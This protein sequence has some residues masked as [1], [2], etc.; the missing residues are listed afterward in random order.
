MGDTK[1]AAE[2]PDNTLVEAAVPTP[3]PPAPTSPVLTSTEP[4]A[5]VAAPTPRNSS[6]FKG[7]IGTGGLEQPLQ[8]SV[9]TQNLLDDK[10]ILSATRVDVR[11]TRVPVLG[12]IQLLA[13]LGQGGMG[14]VYY[15]VH[16]R[17]H[18]EVAVKVL[19]FHLAEQEPG[20][21]P[22]FIREAQ[23][24]AKVRSPHLVGVIDVNEEN[25]LFFLV[26]EFI[27]GK[28][29]GELLRDAA[30]KGMRGLPEVTA[31]G[32]CIGAA[33]GLAAA[34]SHGVIHRDI[35][36][37]N[38]MIPRS[39]GSMEAID[40]QART[41][42]P[43]DA[44]FD[45]LSAKLADLGL[46]RNESGDAS[47]TGANVCMG[48]P[49][50]MSPEQ[51]SDAKHASKPAD[52]FSL[53]ATLYALLSGDSPFK[54]SSL[55]QTLNL[56]V[57]EPHKPITTLRADV[58]PKTAALLDRCLGKKEGDRF[59]D[60]SALLT[61]LRQSFEALVSSVQMSS[62]KTSTIAPSTTVD[63]NTRNVPSSKIS[64][65]IPVSVLP[66][67]PSQIVPAQTSWLPIFATI[68]FMLAIV[69]VGGYYVWQRIEAA[70]RADQQALEANQIS[71]KKEREA[72]IAREQ[73]EAIEK[74]DEMRQA[75]YQ[76]ELRLID[77]WA[78]NQR[79]NEATRRTLLWETAMTA[80]AEFRK[81]RSLDKAIET[82]ENALNN[83]NTIP[84]PGRAIATKMLSDL[85]E[86]RSKVESA[87]TTSL[88]SAAEA[89]REFNFDKTIS[90][91]DA[92][93]KALG[94]QSHPSRKAGEFMLSEAKRN[95]QDA[96]DTFAT[97]YK[98]ALDF[99]R[100]RSWQRVVLTLDSALKSLGPQTHADRSAVEALLKEGR[101]EIDKLKVNGEL[102]MKSLSAAY[103]AAQT[104]KAARNW[105]GVLLALE[106]PLKAIGDQVHPNR[107]AVESLIKE[108]KDQ[109]ERQRLFKVEMEKGAGLVKDLNFDAAKT[110]FENARKTTQDPAELSEINAGLVLVA[111]GIKR[112]KYSRARGWMTQGRAL[113]P[114]LKTAKKGDWTKAL[115]AFKS[116]A[117][118]Y[119][120]LDD[121][122]DLARA[123]IEQGDCLRKD[124]NQNGDW[125]LAAGL[126]SSATVLLGGGVGDK[127]TLAE[128][129]SKHAACLDPDLNPAGDA[130]QAAAMYGRAASMLAETGNKRAAADNFSR[131]ATCLSKEKTTPA[132]ADRTADIFKRAAVLYEELGEKKLQGLCIFN[133]AA[134]LIRSKKSNLT[135]ET[136]A[137]FQRAAKI[138]KEAGDEATQ[139][140]AED[141]LK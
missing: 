92:A 133:Q 57:N 111:D 39:T 13:K 126:Y 106:E 121:K 88:Q 118:I 34:H 78:A 41:M 141:L 36:P 136:R 86:E 44:P 1:Q 104:E 127:K 31:L 72:R 140:L 35:K 89:N 32:I 85:R 130:R 82:V 4:Q 100:A 114:D 27:S 5:T 26:M 66:V 112:N 138:S 42:R 9:K 46:A 110:L 60:A 131:Q 108:A 84:G 47:M 95:K 96:L 124:N 10:L 54:G 70:K 45:Y 134:C 23:I 24:A 101:D 90:I 93:L 65:P 103:N 119:Q 129:I 102:A 77:A 105:N 29:A 58:S 117:A 50:F 51:A 75:A 8:Q 22:R 7:V 63:T 40:P 113:K 33:Q 116:A 81:N 43:S 21:I 14:A 135:L 56:T 71:L 52:V 2:G 38:I 120:E 16:P 98:S 137:L 128:T 37:D 12:G 69:G 122:D 123:T 15:G 25:G 107:V 87:F 62:V 6:A 125:G 17:L 59:S 76:E 11:G 74:E 94:S 109:K 30:L 53:G 64:T 97:A 99:K 48:T 3:P 68:V 19:P 20:L 91:L 132:A 55:M 67:T 139:K 49:G 83:P 28:S 79:N 115:E 73:K 18:Q 80:A 61:A